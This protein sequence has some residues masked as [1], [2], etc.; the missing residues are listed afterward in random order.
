MIYKEIHIYTDIDLNQSTD[1]DLQ[2]I[3][4]IATETSLAFASSS[5]GK[6]RTCKRLCK[7]IKGSK[8]R[9]KETLNEIQ[10]MYASVIVDMVE[11]VFA[12][13]LKN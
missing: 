10:Y 9:Q 13:K 6:S 1:I 3:D 4:Q 5:W 7:V 11:L 2:Q 8:H 12:K